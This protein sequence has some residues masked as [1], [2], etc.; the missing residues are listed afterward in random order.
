M[1]DDQSQGKGKAKVFIPEQRDPWPDRFS[2][3]KLRREFFN[4]APQNNA[5]AMNSIFKEPV[6]WVL[7]KI[8]NK[9]YFKWPNKM[10]GIPPSQ[11]RT[12]N[13]SIIKTKVIRL[14]I[15]GHCVIFWIG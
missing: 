9:S 1:E 13:A 15:V 3:N 8:K 2:P 6:Y 5:Q 14:K 4:Q 10:G 12:Y 7:E 11:I